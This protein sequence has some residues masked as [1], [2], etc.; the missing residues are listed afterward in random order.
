MTVRT[1]EQKRRRAQNERRRYA[2]MRLALLRR[3][4]PELSPDALE[5]APLRRLSIAARRAGVGQG[6]LSAFSEAAG[7]SG[8]PSK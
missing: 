2:K 8:P 4:S 5:R 3:L 1:L 6:T 7:S